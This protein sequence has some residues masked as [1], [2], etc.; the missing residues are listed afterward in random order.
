MSIKNRIFDRLDKLFKNNGRKT[1]IPA[2]LL[3]NADKRSGLSKLNVKTKVLQRESE[4]YQFDTPHTKMIEII[5]EEIMNEIIENGF[6][7]ITL[8]PN[9]INTIGEGEN[10]GGPV[11]VRSRNIT[12]VK[13]KGVI[14]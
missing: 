9:A 11:L 14:R 1:P 7:E 3:N 4:I 10:G 13:G 12:F 5:I 2:P 8:P 6:I